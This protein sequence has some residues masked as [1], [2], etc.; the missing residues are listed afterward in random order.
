M[1]HKFIGKIL[2]LL[3]NLIETRNKVSLYLDS[4][5][6]AQMNGLMQCIH[7]FTQ[8]S[9][10]SF[11]TSLSETYASVNAEFLP[12]LPGHDRDRL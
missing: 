10:E 12:M 6:Q 3:Q 9:G 1:L 7:E 8:K 5:W 11:A 4:R 2:T